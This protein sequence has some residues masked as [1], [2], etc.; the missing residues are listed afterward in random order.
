MTT[1]APTKTLANL[2]AAFNGESNARAKYLAFATKARADG[3]AGVAVL[4]EAAAKAEEIH[5]KAHGEVIKKM[6]A[7]PVAKIEAV[8]PGTTAENLAAAIKGETYE[9]D[10][11]YPDFIKTAKEE[12]APK[13]ALWSFGNALAAEAEHA[14]L[15]TAALA[16]LA[17]WKA[18]KTFLVCSICGF[19]A[20]Q[21]GEKCPVCG[22]K[23][24]NF[25]T[26]K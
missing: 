25:I 16:N 13:A 12:N 1:T 20:E 14:K 24:E 11:M 21:V 19:T 17:Q 3:Y 7:Q 5:A 15:Y 6:G 26:V 9:R 22:N 18:A 4:F 23:R 8:T 2:Q 10:V